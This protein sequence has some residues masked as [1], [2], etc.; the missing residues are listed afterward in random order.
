M[1]HQ[2]PSYVQTS[3]AI[4]KIAAIFYSSKKKTQKKII[5]KHTRRHSV[6]LYGIIK[7]RRRKNTTTAPMIDQNKLSIC[8]MDR[9]AEIFDSRKGSSTSALG[10]LLGYLCSEEAGQSGETCKIPRGAAL[11]PFQRGFERENLKYFSVGKV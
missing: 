10:A 3:A 5:Q 2:L 9:S 6:Q 1:P 8:L 4:N 7:I 11:S